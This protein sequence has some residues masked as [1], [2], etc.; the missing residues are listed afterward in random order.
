MKPGD[1]VRW[2]DPCKSGKSPN[3]GMFIGMRKFKSSDNIRGSHVYECAEVMWVN[4]TAPNGDIISSV[5]H[6]LIEKINADY[7]RL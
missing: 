4:R 6:D 7:D 2:I 3:M 1:L 5:Q